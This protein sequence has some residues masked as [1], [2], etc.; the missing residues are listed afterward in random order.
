MLLAYLRYYAVRYYFLRRRP[1]PTSARA[2]SV[3]GSAKKRRSAI[4]TRAD[5]ETLC[6][7]TAAMRSDRARSAA[8]DSESFANRAGSGGGFFA[9][10]LGGVVTAPT[11]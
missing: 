10:G 9:G 4:S 6:S 7:T 3:A 11:A 5:S 2:C 8:I 1:M